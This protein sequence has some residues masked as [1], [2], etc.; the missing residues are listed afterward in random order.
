M[1]NSK[2]IYL[3]TIH[4]DGSIQP[5]SR[6]ISIQDFKIQ[7]F[8]NTLSE[9]LVD[10]GHTGIIYISEVKFYTNEFQEFFPL[11]LYTTQFGDRKVT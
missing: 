11:D 8:M 3:I 6:R 5:E 7:K 9:I 10:Q 1:T 4:R 2:N